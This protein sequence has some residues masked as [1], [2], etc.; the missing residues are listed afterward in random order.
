LRAGGHAWPGGYPLF[1]ITNDGCTLSFEAVLAKP[2]E[3]FNDIWA[4]DRGRIA[5]VEINYEDAELTCA[6]TG[7]PIPAAYT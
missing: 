4:H 5:A 2:R 7:K 3:F 1:F 6:E